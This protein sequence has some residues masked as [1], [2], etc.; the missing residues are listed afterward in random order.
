IH[1]PVSAT[2]RCMKYSRK[3][4][5]LRPFECM[6]LFI[7]WSNRDQSYRDKLV[8]FLTKAGQEEGL[9]KDDVEELEAMM[10]ID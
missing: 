7:D 8:D 5:F 2:L 6:K 3:G 9:S 4:Y 1:C 10:R